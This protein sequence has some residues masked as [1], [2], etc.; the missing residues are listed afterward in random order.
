MGAKSKW[1]YDDSIVACGSDGLVIRNFYFPSGRSRKIAWTEIRSAKRKRLTILTGKW[2]VWGMDLQR[3]WYHLDF[4][5]P[6]KKE[7]IVIDAG[8]LV[9]I[10]VTPKNLDKVLTIIKQRTTR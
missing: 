7:A 10:G 6:L 9:K 1:F 2:R 8:G 4:L 3:I 5:R